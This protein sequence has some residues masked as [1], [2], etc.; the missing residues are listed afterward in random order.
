MAPRFSRERKTLVY[1]THDSLDFLDV[2]EFYGVFVPREV[3]VVM[4]AQ[5][6]D[7]KIIH[8]TQEYEDVDTQVGDIISD[9]GCT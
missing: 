9:M 1:Q 4:P 3:Q 2:V 5:E 6:E 8:V 7:V